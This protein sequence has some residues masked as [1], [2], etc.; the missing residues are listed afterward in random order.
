MDKFKFEPDKNWWNQIRT[1]KRA[2]AQC[3]QGR[4][5]NRIWRRKKI[6][7]ETSEKNHLYFPN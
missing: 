7:G 2:L 1:D 5:Q 6:L 4:G 3:R